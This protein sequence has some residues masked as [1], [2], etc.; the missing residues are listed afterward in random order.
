VEFDTDR[1][2]LINIPADVAEQIQQVVA[3]SAP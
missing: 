1:E 2:T 3:R